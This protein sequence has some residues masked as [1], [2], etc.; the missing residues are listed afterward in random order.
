MSN[1]NMKKEK[2]KPLK[3]KDLKQSG[4]GSTPPLMA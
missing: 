2:K 1:K 4:G 3:E